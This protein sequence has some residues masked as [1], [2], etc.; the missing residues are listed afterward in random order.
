M[1]F[2]PGS[3]LRHWT[4]QLHSWCGLALGLYAIV[5]GLSG[6][7]LVWQDELEAAEYPDFHREPNPKISTTS[8]Q[9]LARVRAAFPEGR[10][11]SLTW[12]NPGTP[13]WMSYVLLGSEAREVYIDTTSGQVAGVRDPRAGWTGWTGRLHTN[14]LA[15][16]MGRRINT[17]AACLLLGLSVS[18]VILWW[19]RR[20][21][22]Q[23]DGSSGWWKFFWQTHH[24]VG[25]GTVLFIV[26]LSVTGTY[27]YWSSA[28]VRAVS[29]MFAR[30]AEPRVTDAGGSVLDMA[31]I[32]SAALAA[33]PGVPIHRI[34]VVDQPN[35]AVRVTYR[36]A[37]PEEFHLVSTA[38]LHPVTGEILLRNSLAGRPAGDT[39]LTWISALHFGVFG[40]WPVK[41]MW[42]ILSLSLPLLAVS[43]LWIWWG[44]LK[45]A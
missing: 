25:A 32:E 9:A 37:T 5:I 16:S 33:F 2:R 26:L 24:V 7:V 14:L 11:I 43:G 31:H 4:F 17:Y 20:S 23:I 13:F 12:P 6:A 3:K 15:G 10:P 28:Y 44:R 29:G 8:D 34:A 18:G 39:I 21:L 45:R 19:P 30:T 35:Q 27:F 38:F 22:W 40:G 1:S 41:M 42:S 36:E